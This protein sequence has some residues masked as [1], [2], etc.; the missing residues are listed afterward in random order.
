MRP[1]LTQTPRQVSRF[2]RWCQSRKLM[3]CFDE[4]TL[5][6]SYEF[7]LFLIFCLCRW[8]NIKGGRIS[9]GERWFRT[10]KS[11]KRLSR[12]WLHSNLLSCKVFWDFEVQSTFHVMQWVGTPDFM[13]IASWKNSWRQVWEGRKLQVLMLLFLGLNDSCVSLFAART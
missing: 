13:N 7:L 11:C 6:E 4:W 1:F 2:V 9:M 10:H 12:V 3:H 5:F 8:N